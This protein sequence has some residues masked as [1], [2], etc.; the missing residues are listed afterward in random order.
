M[1]RNTK[2]Y[3]AKI[4]GTQ[5]V[6]F[7][8]LTVREL[9]FINGIK[10]PGIK[11]EMAAKIAIT[12]GYSENI[13]FTALNQIGIDVI[14]KSTDCI[15][16]QELLSITV[17]SLRMI[18]QDDM[19]LN[20]I[21]NIMAVIPNITFEYLMEQTYEDLLEL[22]CL[23]ELITG[24]KMFQNKQ[25]FSTPNT[26][27]DPFNGNKTVDLRGVKHTMPETVKKD[28]KTYLHEKDEISLEEKMKQD[29]KWFKEKD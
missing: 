9:S 24:K 21:K 28:G 7:R 12:E 18:V 25:H 10:N 8:T 6:L 11:N 19:A 27:A 14:N 3:K 2:L 29:Q 4:D 15:H 22:L 17:D 26:V 20:L 13:H 5:I 23:C 16:D 1:T